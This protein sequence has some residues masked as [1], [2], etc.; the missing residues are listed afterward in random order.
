MQPIRNIKSFIR[1]SLGKPPRECNED[2][3][4]ILNKVDQGDE[5]S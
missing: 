2:I 3:D 1:Y 5:R 4:E